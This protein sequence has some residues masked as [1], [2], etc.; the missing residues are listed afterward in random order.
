LKLLK[1]WKGFLGVLEQ[2]LNLASRLG[3]RRPAGER[4]LDLGEALGQLR[5]SSTLPLLQMAEGRTLLLVY[6]VVFFDLILFFFAF[7]N[8]ILF[9]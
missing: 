3:E 2:S 1:Q 8:L 5:L 9:F 4:V 6:G 7:F